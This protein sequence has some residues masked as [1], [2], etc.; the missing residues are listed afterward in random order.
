MNKRRTTP[1]KKR[2]YGQTE[3]ERREMKKA[4]S[5]MQEEQKSKGNAI[6]MD[7]H[8]GLFVL[9]EHIVGRC[10]MILSQRAAGK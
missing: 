7:M 5:N 8:A 10:V 6:V 3:G 2:K 9:N 1:S 4:R